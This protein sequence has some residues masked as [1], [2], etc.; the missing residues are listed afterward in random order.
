MKTRRR[1]KNLE[2]M[3]IEFFSIL[4]FNIKLNKNRPSCFRPVKLIE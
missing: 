4:S 3:G 1:E 2:K